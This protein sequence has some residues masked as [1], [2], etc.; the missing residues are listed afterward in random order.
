MKLEIHSMKDDVL[1]LDIE[2]P[3]PKLYVGGLEIND[4]WQPWHATWE[5]IKLKKFNEEFEEA[6][7]KITKFYADEGTR[8]PQSGC[9]TRSAGWGKI[10]S[11]DE[12]W[13]FQNLKILSCKINDTD[14]SIEMEIIFDGVIYKDL[15]TESPLQNANS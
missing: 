3:R 12:Q 8:N 15:R 5:S 10:S 6:K 14:K 2:A 7:L 13:L 11:D 4:D 9:T 1:L